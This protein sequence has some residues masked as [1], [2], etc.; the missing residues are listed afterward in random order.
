MKMREEIDAL[1]T[2]GFNPID[3]LLLP[4]VIA[5]RVHF[6]SRRR[7]GGRCRIFS[8]DS[9]GQRLDRECPDISRDRAYGGN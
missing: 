5:L 2:M 9:A 7:A 1:R 3:V 8:Q 4:P 6:P